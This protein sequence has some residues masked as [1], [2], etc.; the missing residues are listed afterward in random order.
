MRWPGTEGIFS[1]VKRMFCENCVSRSPEGLEAEGY[2]RFWIYDHINQ[3]AKMK[4]KSPD[5]K[6]NLKGNSRMNSSC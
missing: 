1:A 6:G 3:G 2:Q 4:V 5:Y